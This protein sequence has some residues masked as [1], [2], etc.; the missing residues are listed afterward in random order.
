MDSETFFMVW[1]V[2]WL[3]CYADTLLAT[4]FSSLLRIDRRIRSSRKFQEA[5]AARWDEIFEEKEPAHCLRSEKLLYVVEASV[6][7]C[8]CSIVFIAVK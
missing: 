2:S 1:N 7:Y 3:I 5:G 8:V 4:P 6:L